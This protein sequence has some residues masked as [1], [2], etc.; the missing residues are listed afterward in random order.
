MFQ[1]TFLYSSE[2]DMVIH[3]PERA[4]KHSCN[5]NIALVFIT[6]SA[7]NCTLVFFKCYHSLKLIILKSTVYVKFGINLIT[8]V[9]EVQAHL[10]TAFSDTVLGCTK[11]QWSSKFKNGWISAKNDEWDN[12]PSF[13]HFISTCRIWR[14]LAVLSSF[15]HSSLLCIFFL[16]LFPTN[17]SSILSHP[18]LPSISWCTSQSCCSQIHM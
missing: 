6:L 5:G 8:T 9:L 4:V 14:F 7:P 10:R 1:W 17:Y 11:F 3:V 16:P 13:I 18:I 2:T 12:H 15:F